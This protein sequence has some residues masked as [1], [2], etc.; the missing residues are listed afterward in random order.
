M[1]F[2][3]Y[4]L[5]RFIPALALTLLLG[6]GAELASADQFYLATGANG[7]AGSLYLI[8]PAT[9]AVVRTIGPLIDTAGRAYGMTGMAFQPGTNVLYGSTANL[10]PTAP[11]H[12]VRIN[13][14]IGRAHV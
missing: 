4:R 10:S 8:N 5:R 11:G 1:S 13:P 12:L 2:L 9:G 14:E 6:I 7:I 3:S